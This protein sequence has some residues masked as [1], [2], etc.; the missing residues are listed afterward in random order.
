MCVSDT[1]HDSPATYAPDKL[2]S[3][4]SAFNAPT[5]SVS[6]VHPHQPPYRHSYS[7]FV[8]HLQFPSVSHYPTHLSII[9]PFTISPIHLSL[10][11][12]AT[13]THHPLTPH[14][15]FVPHRQFPSPTSTHTHRSIISSSTS[16]HI[17]L[18]PLLLALRFTY[19]P[20]C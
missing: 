1:Q 5:L 2:P 6:P 16:S 18:P 4:H 12:L 9:S 8:P 13:T 20:I 11:P 19:L 17:H 10:H 7:Y 14:T 3:I 15:R